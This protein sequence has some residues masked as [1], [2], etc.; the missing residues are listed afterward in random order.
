MNSTDIPIRM[1]FPGSTAIARGLYHPG[2][3]VLDL[4]W[5]AGPD[6][7]SGRPYEYYRVPL[8]VWQELLA[9]H[10]SGGSVGEF[11]NRRIKEVYR[12]AEKR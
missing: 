9:V 3:K 12:Y 1:E 2:A 6:D 10:A 5:R 11:V 7:P 4:W 8:A